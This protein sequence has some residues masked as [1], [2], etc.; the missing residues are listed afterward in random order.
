MSW[1][2]G[3]FREALKQPEMRAFLTI[4]RTGEGTLGDIGY[5]THFGGSTFDSFDDHP[6]KVI[7]AKLGSNV[8]RSSAAGAGQFLSKTW[9]WIQ[10]IYKWSDFSPQSQDEAMV[11][12]IAHRGALPD[13]LAG[14]LE[15]ALRKVAKE[16]AS[17]PGSPYGQPTIS[18]AKAQSIYNEAMKNVP[19]PVEE[20]TIERIVLNSQPEENEMS[21]FVIAAATK[22][23]DFVPDLV[24]L[25]GGDKKNVERNAEAAEMVVQ[26]AKMV[27]GAATAEEAITQLEASPELQAEFREQVFKERQQIEDRIDKR[28]ESAR[29]FVTN[30]RNGEATLGKFTFPELMTVCFLFGGYGLAIYVLGFSDLSVE[31]KAAVV[32]ALCVQAVSDV[33]GFWFGNTA[34]REHKE[35]RRA[36]Q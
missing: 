13:V 16:W 2:R 8:I 21:P 14:R 7:E 26:V 9:D 34:A 12:L 18:M 28:T 27:T 20:R 6:R 17:L 19:A 22:A 25:F 36:G 15:V 32:G 10:G 3:Q 33:R 29:E 30:Y 4:I 5:R 23:L 35:E 1:T 31:L 24:R 11:A